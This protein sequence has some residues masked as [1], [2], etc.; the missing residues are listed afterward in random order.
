MSS[1]QVNLRWYDYFLFLVGSILSFADPITDILTLLEFYR[2]GH[3]VWFGVGLLF[4]ILPCF[5]FAF[6]IMY[7]R[8][9]CGQA[10][11]CG[12]HPFG[13]AFARL[14]G[15]LLF[16]K[17]NSDDSDQILN[18]IESVTFYEAVLES[19]PQCT[20]QL[21]AIS[22]QDEPVASIQ[23]ISLLVSFLSLA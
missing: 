5:A 9:N 1:P 3:K 4:F 23:I 14:R 16:M 7:S 2:V 15:F 13:A 6:L 18:D 8:G 11:I 17:P 10:I 19:A 12:L 20:I 21:Y 22:V